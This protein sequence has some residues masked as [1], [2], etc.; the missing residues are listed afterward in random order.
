MRVDLHTHSTASDGTDAPADLPRLAKQAG[1]DAFALTDHDTTAGLA[2]AAAAAKK[3]ADAST[4]ANA[5]SAKATMIAGEAKSALEMIEKLAKLSPGYEK[6]VTELKMATAKAN[7]D[8]VTAKKTAD[9]AVAAST[10]AAGKIAG[11]KAA[12][13][14][15]LNLAQQTKAAL[16][17]LVKATAK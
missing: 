13:D 7:Q 4:A 3:A 17:M 12:A 8:A 16:E 10:A 1:L 15:A 6:V 11:A 9:A 2:P 5:A 14:K